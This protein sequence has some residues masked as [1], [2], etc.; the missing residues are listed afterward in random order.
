MTPTQTRFLNM[1]HAE[2]AEV[3]GRLL[4]ALRVVAMN[5]DT[6]GKPKPKKLATQVKA[7]VSRAEGR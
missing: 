4:E 5:L 1:D 7:V 6:Y 2:L 3:A